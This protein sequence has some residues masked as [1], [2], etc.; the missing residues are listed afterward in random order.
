MQ[1]FKDGT[2]VLWIGKTRVSRCSTLLFLNVATFQNISGNT[3]SKYRRFLYWHQNK[4]KLYKC[5]L[6]FTLKTVIIPPACH[7]I[8]NI[9]SYFFCDVKHGLLHWEKPLNFNSLK[10]NCS[11]NYLNLE[12]SGR[13]LHNEER[14]DLCRSPRIVRIKSRRLGWCAARLARWRLRTEF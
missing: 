3:S 12:G 4:N 9:L 8:Q 6:L 1:R 7:D 5:S 2:P 10:E 13:L 14:T 11:A